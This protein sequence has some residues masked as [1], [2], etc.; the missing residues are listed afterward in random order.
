MV[1]PYFLYIVCMLCSNKKYLKTCVY[2]LFTIWKTN[3]LMVF[4]VWSSIAV[5][6]ICLNN[7]GTTVRLVKI[8]VRMIVSGSNCQDKVKYKL[9]YQTLTRRSMSFI[10]VIPLYKIRMYL[11]FLLFTLFC[12]L[13]ASR[14]CINKKTTALN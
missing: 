10:I 3:D 4:T 6:K 1:K 7:V 8:S 2:M 5:M 9:N 12:V 13:M 14:L 11:L